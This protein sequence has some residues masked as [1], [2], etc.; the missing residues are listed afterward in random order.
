MVTR[1]GGT[2]A[3]A[4]LVW[5]CAV[6]GLGAGP[7]GPGSA[8]AGTRIVI[9]SG[10]ALKWVPPHGGAP[11]TLVAL[12]RAYGNTVDIAASEDGRRIAVLRREGVNGSHGSYYSIY[13]SK[14]GS[15]LRR[16]LSKNL[17][18]VFPG[19]PTIALS[20]KGG[21]IALAVGEKIRLIP[22]GPGR[23]RHFEPIDACSY[24]D[25]SFS[26]GGRRIVFSCL[27]GP[28]SPR[29]GY[30]IY[31]APLDG[32][33]ASRLTYDGRVDEIAPA[34]S[35]DGRLVAYVSHDSHVEEDR[36]ELRVSWVGSFGSRFLAEVTAHTRPEFSPRGRS[37][38]YAV[39]RNPETSYGKRYTLFTIRASGENRRRVMPP[40]RPGPLVPQWTRGPG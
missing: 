13:T 27:R 23:V 8:K 26:A 29:R 2:A 12:P 38:V 5:M 1:A 32:G 16:R 18:D 33:P 30:D 21:T 19:P 39:V 22:F 17:I 37:L 14:S 36:F 31:S 7:L 4:V 15:P 24:E 35:P 25:P 34:L 9:A 28:R 20:P 40:S 11:R 3:L 6:A 10:N